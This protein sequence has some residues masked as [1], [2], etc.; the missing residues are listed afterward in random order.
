MSDW[1]IRRDDEKFGPYSTR[2]LRSFAAEGRLQPDDKVWKDGLEK[3]I[4]ARLIKGLFASQSN[5]DSS[6]SPAARSLS[7]DDDDSSFDELPELPQSR[8]TQE[9][10]R[11]KEALGHGVDIAR[12]ALKTGTER[13]RATFGSA[14]KDTVSSGF[15]SFGELLAHP[16]QYAFGTLVLLI[17]CALSVPGLVTIVLIPVF[18]LGY[19]PYV[20]SILK[21]EPASLGKFINF[22][23]H[24]WDS[25][26]HLLMLLGT[27]F[28]AAA[29]AIAPFV[30]AGIILY[31]TVGTVSLGGLQIM[32]LMPT[33]SSDVREGGARKEMDW[34]R[35]PQRIPDAGP[36][37]K[38]GFMTHVLGAINALMEN[39]VWFVGLLMAGLIGT[40]LL[41]PSGSI[42]I[43][44]YCI[45]LMVAT[46]AS[47]S[48][49]KYDLVYEAFERMLLIAHSEWKRLLTSGLW[50]VALPIVWVIL[51]TLLSS[52]LI[53]FRLTFIDAWISLVIYPLVILGFAI[54]VNI[55]SVKTAMRLVESQE[56][57]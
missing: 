2:E 44:V 32:S 50:L 18:V 27:F 11:A 40:A 10:A 15:A 52:V 31:A 20:E 51:T 55:F 19:I 54:Y 17:A 12:K 33:G 7:D 28:I 13:L 6:E 38:D 46:R 45:T 3:P 16:I 8:S 43:L 48:E 21:R 47:G 9:R 49:A 22:M 1:Y 4:R 29:L 30:I 26:W 36:Q 14:M 35:G 57:A 5:D 23:R 24:G 37:D 56:A 42:L 34:N 41:T 25:L 53:E 39:A